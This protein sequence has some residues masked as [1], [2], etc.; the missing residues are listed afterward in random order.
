MKSIEDEII[1]PPTQIAL[2]HFEY[3]MIHMSNPNIFF[4]NA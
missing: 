3:N 4:A 2:D 1:F